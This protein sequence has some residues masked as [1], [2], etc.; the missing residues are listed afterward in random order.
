[1]SAR[2]ERTRRLF[3]ALWPDEAM[4][5]ALADATHPILA[6][7]DGAAV[8]ARNFH[9]TLAFLG[10]VPESRAREL[11]EI[12]TRVASAFQEVAAV[13]GARAAA[14]ASHANTEARSADAPIIITLDRIEHWHKSQILCA[15]STAEPVEAIALAETLKRQ[16]TEN[17]FAPDLKPFRAHATLA[18]KVRHV[19]RDRDMPPVHWSFH[20]CRLI[21]SETRPSGSLYSTREIFVLD[22]MLR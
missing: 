17:G 14:S 13:R 2:A 4:Q 7:A 6:T 3:F 21:E 18:R 9:F 22:A 15:T 19:T 12:A 10:A 20:E 8:P 1:V 16:L 5:A 11:G